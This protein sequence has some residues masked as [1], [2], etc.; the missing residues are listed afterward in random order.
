MDGQTIDFNTWC[1]ELNRLSVEE[2]GFAIPYIEQT[3]TECWKESYDFGHSPDDAIHDSL[4]Y[5]AD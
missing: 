5:E 2:Y 3:G 1:G 4:S